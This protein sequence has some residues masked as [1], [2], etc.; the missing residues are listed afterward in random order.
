MISS[1]V[2]MNSLLFYKLNVKAGLIFKTFLRYPSCNMIK[3]LFFKAF[4]IFSA[5]SEAA[6]IVYLDFTNSIPINN[7]YPLT[8]PTTSY[9]YLSL[10]NS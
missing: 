1:K 4:E 2:L 8:S 5:S 9:F 10:F 3:P 7:P 6:S